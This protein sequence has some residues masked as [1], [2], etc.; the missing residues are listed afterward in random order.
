MTKIP[1][2][3]LSHKHDQPIDLH[4][5]EPMDPIKPNS[6]IQNLIAKYMK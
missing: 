3:S 2:E 5:V 4:I 1:F 6:S